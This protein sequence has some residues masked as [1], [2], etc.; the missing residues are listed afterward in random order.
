MNTICNYFMLLDILLLWTCADAEVKDRK[1]I[2]Y[3]GYEAVDR[4]ELSIKPGQV[5][6][7]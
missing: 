7:Q 3:F 5:H 4:D 6:P 1:A 2:V